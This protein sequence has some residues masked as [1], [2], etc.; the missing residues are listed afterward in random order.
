MNKKI[1]LALVLTMICMSGCGKVYGSSSEDT[2]AAAIVEQS[3]AAETESEETAMY[4]FRNATA[5][6]EKKMWERQY[7][8][9]WIYDSGETGIENEYALFLG[10]VI[11]RFGRNDSFSSDWENMYSYPIVVESEQ[12]EEL[13]IE[14]YHGSGGPSYSIPTDFKDDEEKE[15]YEQAAKALVEYI[16]SAEPADYELDTKYEDAS[17]WIKYSVKDGVPSHTDSFREKCKAIEEKYGNEFIDNLDM[18]E[19]QRVMYAYDHD[20]PVETIIEMDD[21]EYENLSESKDL[22]TSK[23]LF[24]ESTGESYDIIKD[25]DAYDFNRYSM[26]FNSGLDYEDIKDMSLAEIRELLQQSAMENGIL[27]S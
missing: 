13:L 15:K 18:Y 17:V 26:A 22:E 10:K 19:W 7:A 1:T 27:D 2:D 4:K 5:E 9:E 23:K 14:I 25:M 11:A 8:G 16:Q 6:E 12:G 24:A 3:T 20:I 21:R